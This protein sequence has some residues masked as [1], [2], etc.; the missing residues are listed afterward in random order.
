MASALREPKTSHDEVLSLEVLARRGPEQHKKPPT[1]FRVL[2]RHFLDR[3]FNNEMASAEGDAKTRLV[4]VACTI[5]IP[6]F[7]VALYL[8]T[9][10]H[11]PHQVRP[12]WAQVGDHYFYTLYSMVAMG[13]VTI[14]EW[15]LLFPD[16]LDVIVLSPLPVRSLRMLGARVAAIFILM[17]AALF[18]SSFLAPVVLPAA[19]DPPHLFRFWAAHLLAV[20]ASGVFGAAFFLALEGILVGVMGDQLF[21]RIALWLQG[22]SVVALLTLLFLYPAIAGSLGAVLHTQSR[23]VAWVPSLWFLGIYQRILDG[24]AT[25]AVFSGLARTGFIA[26][27]TTVVLAVVSYPLAWWRRTRALVE[28]TA[29]R[30]KQNRIALPLRRALHVTLARQPAYRA[31]WQFIGQNLLRVPRYRMVL[32]MYGGMGAALLFATVTRVS[33]AHGRLAFVFSPQGLRATVP[34]VA[35]WTVSGLRSTFLAPAD[36]RGRWIFRVILGKAGRAELNACQRWV[37]L[38]SAALSLT[39]ALISV[40]AGAGPRD[41]RFAAGQLIVALGL[42][43][44]LT[45][46]FFLTVKTIPFTG[47]RP[48]SATNF[49]LLL[50][51]YLG[52]FP[53]IVMFTIGLEPVIEASA[54]HLAIAVGLM[55]AA[56]LVLRA[57]HRRRMAEHLHA[58][59]AD[60]D[61][62]DFPLRLGLRY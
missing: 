25:P 34:I 9:P 62:E 33:V 19:V 2:I 43:L 21:R 53:A 60:D 38:W 28:G 46:A 11:M 39:A 29:K 36:Q 59:E 18:D 52:F 58:I 51:P 61:E 50:I 27:T 22:A 3:F 44:L 40:L 1:Q 4:Q 48:N 6:P 55:T 8:Y 13:I 24:P 31:M 49:A 47:V 15:D 10:Y 42:S 30:E 14:F 17:A 26:V 57:I 56:H 54:A 23:L 16:L 7:V 20:A 41:W 35:F 12:Y 37:F 45:D 5:G 32:V